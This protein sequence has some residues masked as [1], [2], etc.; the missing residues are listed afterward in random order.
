MRSGPMKQSYNCGPELLARAI[1]CCTFPYGPGPYCPTHRAWV[2]Y[3]NAPQPPLA[4]GC[5]RE[6][7][8][9]DWCVNHDAYITPG[10]TRCWNV[11]GEPQP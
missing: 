10:D 2:N 3:L 8:G 6:G 4:V 5:L 1:H 11:A 7:E 9:V